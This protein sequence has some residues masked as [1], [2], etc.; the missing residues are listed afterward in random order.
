MTSTTPKFRPLI[1]KSYKDLLTKFHRQIEPGFASAAYGLQKIVDKVTRVVNSIYPGGVS[2]HFDYVV[3]DIHYILDRFIQADE[4]KL[5][6]TPE[7]IYVFADALD[8]RFDKLV[9]LLEE[10]DTRC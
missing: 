6:M 9:K 2:H 4:N 5:Y 1:D 3:N 8:I 7:E 10:L